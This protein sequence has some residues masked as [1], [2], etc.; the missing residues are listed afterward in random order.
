MNPSF[1]RNMAVI[2]G[3]LRLLEM[4]FKIRTDTGWNKGPMVATCSMPFFGSWELVLRRRRRMLLLGAVMVLLMFLRFV[5]TRTYCHSSS[6][7]D[8]DR[9][10]R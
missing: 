3:R 8:P 6:A 4:G 7:A 10:R 2:D 1:F 5:M 9:G